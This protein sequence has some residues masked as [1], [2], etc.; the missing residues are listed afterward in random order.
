MEGGV[1]CARDWLDWPANANSGS[2]PSSLRWLTFQSVSSGFQFTHSHSD[3]SGCPPP[4]QLLQLSRRRLNYL[5]MD[6]IHRTA[7]ASKSKKNTARKVPNTVPK[8]GAKSVSAT[9][10]DLKPIDDS[11]VEMVASEG[12]EGGRAMQTTDMSKSFLFHS[13]RA[14]QR[15]AGL[16]E[17]PCSENSVAP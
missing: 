4:Q 15:C 14:N 9:N 3:D 11:D 7:P 12:D 13:S 16:Q 6:S 8:P 1:C 5:V 17:L 10:I 2:C